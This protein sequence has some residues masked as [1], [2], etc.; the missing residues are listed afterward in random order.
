[1]HFGDIFGK[2]PQY[3]DS[4][5]YKTND[6]CLYNGNIVIATI[7]NPGNPGTNPSNWGTGQGGGEN[8]E[9]RVVTTLPASGNFLYEWIKRE[10]DPADEDDGAY[11]WTG[12]NW[13]KIF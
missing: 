9:A 5:V 10:N 3:S 2:I 1:M 11:V 6:G 7:D 13:Y 8:Q 12:T 4:I